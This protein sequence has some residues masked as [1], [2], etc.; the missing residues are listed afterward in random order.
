MPYADMSVY[1][2]SWVGSDS[3]NLNHVSSPRLRVGKDPFNTAFLRSYMKVEGWSSMPS[4]AHITRADFRFYVLQLEKTTVT[5]FR[6]QGNSD[7][8]NPNIVTWSNQP[9]FATY[10]SDSNIVVNNTGWFV[11]D[12]LQFA[13][14]AYSNSNDDI[15]RGIRL[16]EEDTPR[17]GFVRFA[18]IDHSTKG[19]HPWMRVWYIA[20][21]PSTTSADSINGGSW[22]RVV[23]GNVDEAW[24]V[25]LY[26]SLS[27]NFS[28][29]VYI[30]L[31]NSGTVNWSLTDTTLIAS[32]P[33]VPTNLTF[34]QLYG[35]S[36]RLK[37]DS[38][39]QDNVLGYYRAKRVLSD[40]TESNYSSSG[41]FTGA[42]RVGL[43]PEM[44]H[45]VVE[46]R[47][48]GEAVWEHV[49][50]VAGHAADGVGGTYTRIQDVTQEIGVSYQYR[51]RGFNT[52]N[53]ASTFLTGWFT[54]EYPASPSIDTV[55][56]SQGATE[57]N[58]VISGTGNGT[59]EDM[60][61]F[62]DTPT[63]VEFAGSI[64][65]GAN[66]SK[67]YL[68][69]APPPNA[70]S[71]TSRDISWSK[72][73]LGWNIPS[74]PPLNRTFRVR[75]KINGRWSLFSLPLSGS[76]TPSISKYFLHRDAGAGFVQISVPTTNLYDDTNIT[77]GS[78][79]SYRILAENSQGK[80]SGW[81]YTDAYRIPRALA[82][83]LNKF[84]PLGGTISLFGGGVSGA[85]KINVYL[86]QN[87]NEFRA[88]P[89]WVKVGEGVIS[90]D[91]W[92][93]DHIPSSRPPFTVRWRNSYVDD[94]GV[95][96]RWGV[97]RNLPSEY[98]YRA[99]REI[100]GLEGDPSIKLRTYSRPK[101][102]NYILQRRKTPKVG[103]PLT[104]ENRWATI[105]EGFIFSHDDISTD[106][107]S[108]YDYRVCAVNEYGKR[109]NFSVL[110]TFDTNDPP[111][112]SDTPVEMI[113]PPYISSPEP[114]GKVKDT[115][116]LMVSWM[117]AD[118]RNS[119]QLLYKLKVEWIDD[120]GALVERW[121]DG[122]T[123]VNY[124]IEVESSTSS[125]RVTDI[126]DK[127][128]TYTFRLRV[129]S[130][131]KMME[132]GE[133]IM[134]QTDTGYTEDLVWQMQTTS[135]YS[136]HF[137]TRR[138]VRRQYS[139]NH[140]TYRKVVSRNP[141][142][143]FGIKV[144]WNVREQ[145]P[146]DVDNDVWE[147]GSHTW[148]HVVDND[149]GL[150]EPYAKIDFVDEEGITQTFTTDLRG[151][152]NLLIPDDLKPGIYTMRERGTTFPPRTTERKAIGDTWLVYHHGHRHAEDGYDPIVGIT[153]NQIAPDAN[154]DAGM[155]EGADSLKFIVDSYGPDFLLN[156]EKR[157]YSGYG[158][159][160]I[161]G[162]DA[163][164][165]SGVLTV[166]AGVCIEGGRV[167]EMIQN[168]FNLL[169]AT[170]YVYV[171]GGEMIA[172]ER[173][174]FP[175]DSAPL[176]VVTVNADGTATIDDRRLRHP[177][178]I[179]GK[180]VNPVRWGASST[181]DIDHD[182]VTLGEVLRYRIKNYEEQKL[183]QETLENEF[184]G[185]NQEIQS[186]LDE[187]DKNTRK[188]KEAL[189]SIDYVNSMRV[190]YSLFEKHKAEEALVESREYLQDT[191]LDKTLN[192]LETMESGVSPLVNYVS[193]FS[194]KDE[195]SSL[196]TL[197]VREGLA[198]LPHNWTP[199]IKYILRTLTISTP[200]VDSLEFHVV[201]E[202]L[203]QT[204][205]AYGSLSSND[206]YYPR[207]MHSKRVVRDDNLKALFGT[208]NDVFI[209]TFRCDG[210]G[211]Q[212]I[213]ELLLTGGIQEDG[214]KIRGWAVCSA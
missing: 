9:T 43:R 5:T 141:E 164:W 119:P 118:R 102:D 93:F 95:H 94:T 186:L 29:P 60:Q 129:L 196:T 51:I 89:S 58:F 135:Y 188:A 55:T 189:L 179:E 72:I 74:N 111:M 109:G 140:D 87:S 201:Y 41:T 142:E 88:E 157:I 1:A 165:L 90:G 6:L 12:A 153:R 106:S 138:E 156:L 70:I 166:S 181:A 195:L 97:S 28:S 131:D 16:I 25:R 113:S 24:G 62:M 8:W 99:R 197:L 144:V 77:Q 73:S 122:F 213:V 76:F 82:P 50:T 86:D 48:G 185:N 38:S 34:T 161:E 155:V 145:I 61:L 107:V 175:P 66:F 112:A 167:R 152:I 209:E 15:V 177:D 2:D 63:G 121:W 114:R 198:T 169:T 44:K 68:I 78:T 110:K 208:T 200:P 171:F 64:T 172:E 21:A 127:H 151:R 187:N 133:V 31:A 147:G 27:E 176:Y 194:F 23:G 52:Q 137:D 33:N 10:T 117:Y 83:T 100:D 162:M 158:N 39:R 49:N 139:Q 173:I 108:E 199:N 130:E 36:V 98:Y 20:L 202:D 69:D 128:R 103:T 65:V 150:P 136:S 120:L 17:D 71:Q 26:R 101:V 124:E 46:R 125:A 4:G 35:H 192:Y 180:T 40:G 160:V 32:N 67:N 11:G 96:L 80:R 75:Q 19:F 104:L 14:N 183:K 115:S 84:N 7:N 182:G 91:K 193:N 148:S 53:R 174:D 57:D 116:K 204:M 126:F 149:N 42:H 168:T 205:E 210:E 211:D 18:S 37:W 191:G 143:G 214:V 212:A 85:T 56:V 3:P 207:R 159:F 92:T 134:A 123:W 190:L 203:G 154:I 79:Y 105:A 22:A 45:Y 47:K 59:A 206:F 178:N 184:Y 54:V 146:F 170:Y 163:S 132:Q 13:R 30:G 81:I